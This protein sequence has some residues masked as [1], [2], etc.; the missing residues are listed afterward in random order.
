MNNVLSLGIS[1]WSNVLSPAFFKEIR[2]I[3]AFYVR[4]VLD[5]FDTKLLKSES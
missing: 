5:Y 4:P 1:F 3:D 2:L